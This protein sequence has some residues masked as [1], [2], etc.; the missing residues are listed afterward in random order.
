[1]AIVPVTTTRSLPD[2]NHL[3]EGV[4]QGD[5][6]APV[7]VLGGRYAIGAAGDFSDSAAVSLQYSP[8]GTFTYAEVTGGNFTAAGYVVVD[9]PDG[10]V[11]PVVQDGGGDTDLD[12][13]LRPIRDTRI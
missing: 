11:K 5:E 4:G 10:F 3:W 7:K 12:I 6:G 13:Y 1:M 9:F 2:D 8:D